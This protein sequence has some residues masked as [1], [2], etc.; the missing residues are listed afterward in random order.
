M[1]LKFACFV[2][3]QHHC[4][5]QQ[6]LTQRLYIYIYV[7]K[8]NYPF[9]IFYY[10]HNLN[11]NRL[12]SAITSLICSKSSNDIIRFNWIYLV[13]FVRW[14]DFHLCIVTE[15]DQQ[16]YYFFLKEPKLEVHFEN[17]EMIGLR[18]RSITTPSYCA[19]KCVWK[20]KSSQVLD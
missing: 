14:V 20:V 5:S 2:E 1:W 3:Q 6:Y 15:R 13:K 4:F 17:V 8:R 10:E 19:E 9:F 18:V 7:W 11:E 12:V 16:K